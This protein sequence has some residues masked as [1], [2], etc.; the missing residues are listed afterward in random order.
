MNPEIPDVKV[1]KF[2]KYQN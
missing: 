2:R 1:W